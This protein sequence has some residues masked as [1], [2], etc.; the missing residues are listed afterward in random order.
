MDSMQLNQFYEIGE[1]ISNLPTENAIAAH[2]S[3]LSIT[4]IQP[5]IVQL[6]GILFHAPN[7]MH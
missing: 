2:R 7:E 5:S 4:T 6:K 3:D 1:F